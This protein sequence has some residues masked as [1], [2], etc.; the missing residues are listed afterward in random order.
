MKFQCVGLRAEFA[1]YAA[2][3]C[4]EAFGFVDAGLYVKFLAFGIA[5]PVASEG[6]AFEEQFGA[7]AGTVVYCETLY[8]E[9]DPLGR[10]CGDSF[11]LGLVTIISE[12]GPVVY[13]PARQLKYSFLAFDM[14]LE[15]N[16][17]QISR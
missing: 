8:V 9:Y 11:R 10:H 17:T 13:R 6:T 12:P 15:S 16:H 1:A 3:C 7:Q 14:K 5:A 4:G 2:F